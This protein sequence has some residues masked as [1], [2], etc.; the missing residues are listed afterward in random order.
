MQRIF[1]LGPHPDDIAF[2]CAGS[3]LDDV[4]S[5]HEVTLV[6][7]FVS[8]EQAATRRAEDEQAAAALGCKYLSLDLFEAPDRPEVSGSLGLF[9]PYGPPHL[10]ITSEVV[11]RLRWHISEGAHLVAPLAAGGHIDHRIVHEAARS[12]SFS[13]GLPIAYFEDLPYSL[14]DFA[15]AR[16]LAALE[17]PVPKLP[18]TTRASRSQ[19]IAAYRDYLRKL[20]VMRRWPIGLR[21]LGSHIAARAVFAADSQGQRP[22]QRPILAPTLRVVSADHPARLAALRAYASQW[23]LFADSPESLLVR[24]IDYGRALGDPLPKT[25]TYERTWQ[26]LSLSHGDSGPKSP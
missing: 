3:V 22:G 5:G 12:L 7:I 14:A 24:I 2:S 4:A 18:G 19:E 21:A 6:S 1:Y 8:G 16:R 17:A 15:V 20:P 11:T 23:P 26:D 10:G 13:L 25:Q 9:M